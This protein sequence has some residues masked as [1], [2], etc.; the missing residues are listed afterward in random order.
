VTIAGSALQAGTWS[1]SQARITSANARGGSGG[2]GP[3]PFGLGILVGL[4]AELEELLTFGEQRL[5]M[6]RIGG[7]L[8]RDAE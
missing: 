4:A 6:C 3:C 7:V 1:T 5:G 8:G 2:N